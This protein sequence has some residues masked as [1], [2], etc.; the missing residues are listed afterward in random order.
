[1]YDSL[2]LIVPYHL[3][4]ISPIGEFHVE[5]LLRVPDLAV[6]MDLCREENSDSPAILIINKTFMHVC[7]VDELL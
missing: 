6:F 5:A 4:G 1:M 2:R 3:I 7:V